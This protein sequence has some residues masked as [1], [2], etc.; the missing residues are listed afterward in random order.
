MRTE[1][2]ALQFQDFSWKKPVLRLLSAKTHKPLLL[3]HLN[4]GVTG[5]LTDK[6][7]RP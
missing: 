5:E 6:K 3:S 7:Q 1:N 2:R 4:S